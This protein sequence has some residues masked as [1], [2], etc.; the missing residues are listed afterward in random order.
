MLDKI[1]IVKPAEIEK[2]SMEI[3]TS[4]LNGRTW[5]EPEFSIVK[6]CIHTSAD[7]DYADNLIDEFMLLQ[8]DRKPEHTGQNRRETLCVFRK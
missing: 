1:Q 2:R 3:I 4:E 5:P 8:F 6:R 7:F